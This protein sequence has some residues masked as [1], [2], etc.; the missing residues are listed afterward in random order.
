MPNEI[1]AAM[2]AAA[3][4]VIASP[5]GQRLIL[6]SPTS[7]AESRISLQ[8][9]ETI[10]RRRFVTRA[11]I[12]DEAT[13][14]IFGFINQ[15]AR[16]RAATAARLTGTV[17][18]SRGVDLR[19]A[20]FL[21]LAVDGQPACAIDFSTNTT[22]VPRL[23]V[24]LPGEI[25]AAINAALGSEVATHDGSRLTLTSRT[26]GAESRIAFEAP[27]SADASSVLLGLRTRRD[28]RA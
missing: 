1:V 28:T 12:T 4:S 18:L 11:F 22:S 10:R 8:P 7:G 20:R 16:G 23:R 17:D 14:A 2:N 26:T 3:G 13:Q 5:D 19:E 15:S 25:V 27:R 9:V 24:A 21:R 6:T